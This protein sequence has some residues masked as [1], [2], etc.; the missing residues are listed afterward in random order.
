MMFA[1]VSMLLL[2][3]L[4]IG[5]AIKVKRRLPVAVH[6]GVLDRRTRLLLIGALILLATLGALNSLPSQ[7]YSYD[8]EQ[9]WSTF[10]GFTALG[11]VG[12][13]VIALMV[14]GL[15]LF[16]Q[17]LRRRVG[18]PML[19]GGSARSARTEMLI[20]GLGLGGVIYAATS[21]DTLIPSA[22]MP[23]APSTALNDFF[24]VLSGLAEI[25]ASAIVAVT[26]VG[27]PMLVVVGLT[28]RRITRA[29]IIAAIVVL[30]AAIAFSIGRTVDVDAAR[31]TLFVASMIAVILAITAWGRLAAWSWIIAA[32]SYQALGGLRGGVYGPEWQ[33][34]GAGALTVLVAIALIALVVRASQR[35]WDRARTMDRS[36]APEIR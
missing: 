13:V 28:T 25:P 6:D 14:V 19:A 4:L 32:L 24:P 31:L 9:P 5:G 2:F 27:V 33:A 10:V 26:V 20:A 23:S 29:L 7:L 11:F 8:T 18:I 17:A 12:P 21:L 15:L 16:L 35:G 22:D 3:V 1:G 34:R 30:L 36:V